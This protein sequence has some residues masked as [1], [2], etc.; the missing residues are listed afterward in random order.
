MNGCRRWI[1]VEGSRILVVIAGPLIYLVYGCMYRSFSF[2]NFNQKSPHL[3]A[4]IWHVGADAGD[5]YNRVDVFLSC[6]EAEFDG[7]R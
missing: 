4:V 3:L 5:G 2:S 7:G 6:G 1:L